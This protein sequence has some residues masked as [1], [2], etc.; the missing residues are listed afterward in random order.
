MNGQPIAFQVV[1]E[2]IPTTDPGPYSLTLYRDNPVITLRAS[3]TGSNGPVTFAYNWLA[4]C[5]NLG[6]E[7]TAPR[8]NE[9]VASQTAVVG[10][11]YNLNLV[12][13]FIDQET[14]DQITLWA[15]GLPA[16]LTLS[17][18]QITGSVS[19]TVGSPYSVTLTATDGG[20]LRTSTSF[21]LT[22]VPAPVTPPPPTSSFSI[23]GVTTVSCQV[24]PAGQ[25]RLTFS[26]QY[27]GLDGSPVSFSVVNEMLPTTSPGPYTL[28]LYTDNPVISLR[29][30]QGGVVAVSATGGWRPAIRVPVRRLGRR[31]P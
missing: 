9:P 17:G 12:N 13:T 26:P 21:M 22:V 8:L 1:N 20:G 3:Q 27:A 25:R 10:Q 7:N 6:Q 2:S 29:A 30:V 24:L 23:T 16:G 5:S 19:S 11:T 14:P 28:D 15:S 31:C 4:A 18:K